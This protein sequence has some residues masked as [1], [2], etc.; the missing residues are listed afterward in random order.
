M[1]PL[2]ARPASPARL[3]AWQTQ[4]A[5][6]APASQPLRQSSAL[7]PGPGRSG[8]R[9]CAWRRRRG[10]PHEPCAG[11]QPSCV[12]ISG[13]LDPRAPGATERAR[14]PR[15]RRLPRASRPRG[16]FFPVPLPLTGPA[17]AVMTRPRGA[18]SAGGACARPSISQSP[19]GP[20]LRC[21][22][23]ARA[24]L[25]SRAARRRATSSRPKSA[26][27]ARAHTQRITARPKPTAPRARFTVVLPRSAPHPGSSMTPR[28]S[29]TPLSAPR[30]W[31]A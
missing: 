9:P 31:R 3:P 16:H 30:H 18:G 21:S 27:A 4:W 28:H 8:E 7:A 15:A 5:R 26:Q 29:T 11:R 14:C 24:S 10:F 13:P 17:V 2:G 1:P 19:M 25:A 6:V 22:S 12:H 23:S 20:P